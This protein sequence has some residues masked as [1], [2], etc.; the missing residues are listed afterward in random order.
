MYLGRIVE[1]GPSKNIFTDPK[2]PYTKA[3][4][5]AI[6]IPDPRKRTS[7][8]LPRGEVPDAVNPPAGCRFHP[9]C[10]AVLPT[11]GWEGRDF[12][13]YLEG[14]RLD[15][16]HAEQDE[17]ILGPLEKWS[18]RGLSAAWKIEGQDTAAII[19]YLKDILRDA[20]LQMTRAVQTVSV[21]DDHVVVEFQKPDVLLEKDVDGRTVE[22]LLYQ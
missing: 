12:I 9:R 20:N 19:V 3:L 22:C 15:P 10:L 13:D 17:Q 8:T 4:L 18:T 21:K 14:R 6:P 5:Q 2:H 11:C 1:V 7:K 16:R